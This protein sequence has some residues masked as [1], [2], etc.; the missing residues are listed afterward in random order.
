MRRT[1]A[2]AMHLVAAVASLAGLTISTPAMA[3]GWRP[4]GLADTPVSQIA[5]DQATPNVIYAG[6]QSPG[7]SGRTGVRKTTDGGRGWM[8]LERGL[9]AGFQPTALAVSAAEGA[10]VLAGAIDGMFRSS[11]GGATWAEVR[12]PLPPITALLFDRANPQ[13]AL[14][15]SELRGNYRSTDGGLTW[16]PASL[17]LPTDHYG[18]TPGAVCFAQHPTEPQIIYMGTNGFAGVYKSTDGGKTWRPAGHGLPNPSLRAL[19]INPATP[20]TVLA[21]TDQG[22]ARSTD[23]G[24][25]WQAVTSLPPIEPVAVLYEPQAKDTIYVAGARGGLYRSTNGGAGWV[26]LPSLPRPV[27]ALAMTT[28]TAPSGV[29]ALA[30]AAGE[31]VWQLPLPPTLPA[32]PEQTTSNRRFFPETGHNVSPTFYPFYLA[33]GGLDR[34][35]LPR[36]EEFVEDGVLVQ[37]FQRARLEYHPEFR[38]TPYEIQISLIG[39]WLV[40]QQRPP[41][42]EPF[43]SS[44]EQRYFE[45]TGHSVNYAFLRYFNTRGGLDSFGFPITEELQENGRPVQYFQRARLEYHAEAMGTR[46]EVQVGAVGDQVL[47]QR[48]W[49]D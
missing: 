8:P 14:A 43:E 26:E 37:Y 38:N 12:Q 18:A 24:T 6:V 27:R 36:T 21:V 46:D 10:I 47:R 44:A 39:E 25:G 31:G 33:R 49:L 20:D 41:P 5:L 30:A 45:E 19:A 3:A 2:L 23:G 11:T 7:P 32:S 4:A 16:R 28:S 48:G 29:R 22:L 35:G 17:G 34:F 15:G 1:T 42:I 40:G 9:P 13:V